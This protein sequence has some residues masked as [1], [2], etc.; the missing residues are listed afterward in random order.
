MKHYEDLLK[1]PRR[2]RL[3]GPGIVQCYFIISFY[4]FSTYSKATSMWLIRYKA[5]TLLLEKHKP[6]EEPLGLIGV[7]RVF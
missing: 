3:R 5:I 6:K 4:V 1:H 2:V 7:L